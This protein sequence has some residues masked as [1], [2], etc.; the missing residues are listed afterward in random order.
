MAAK[1]VEKVKGDHGRGGGGCL[2]CVISTLPNAALVISLSNKA[3]FSLL[4]GMLLI[5]P[6]A[7]LILLGE[8]SSG[9]REGFSGDGVGG[10]RNMLIVHLTRT[11]DGSKASPVSLYTSTP[12]VYLGFA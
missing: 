1:L 12:N 7:L 11:G 6:I 9:T 3:R 8:L 10:V 5:H 2:R 4:I